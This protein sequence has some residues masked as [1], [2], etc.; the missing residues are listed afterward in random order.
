MTSKNFKGLTDEQADA[1]AR[2]LRFLWPA[3]WLQTERGVWRCL[4][5]TRVIFVLAGVVLLLA[6]VILYLG[7]LG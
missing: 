1:V 4:L 6:G 5:L 2:T 3:S 7:Y